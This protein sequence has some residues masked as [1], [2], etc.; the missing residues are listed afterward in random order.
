MRRNCG[1]QTE[2]Y[3]RF[4]KAAADERATTLCLCVFTCGPPPASM[5]SLC[6]GENAESR[7]RQIFE[8]HFSRYLSAPG[9]SAHPEA[10]L[11]WRWRNLRVR[12]W[13]G[14]FFRPFW[15]SV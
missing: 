15:A 3:R 4:P 12:A 1:L 2:C 14:M 11:A 7:P 13:Q 10:S 6:S 5:A 8:C 9:W